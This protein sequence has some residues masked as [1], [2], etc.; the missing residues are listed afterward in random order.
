MAVEA[1]TA[2][3][4]LRGDRIPPHSE[5]AEQGVLGSILLDSEK[6][7][8]LCIERQLV[9]ES[10]YH[11]VYLTIFVA[12]L[13]MSRQNRPIDLVTATEKLRSSGV[14]ERIGGSLTLDRLVDSTPTAAHAEY[15]IDIV[16]HKHLLRCVIDRARQAESL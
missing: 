8:N 16:R 2:A 3:N 11:P 6:V 12:L 9:P 13:E 1:A 10:F 14:M 7:M 4:I 5:E 15:Y